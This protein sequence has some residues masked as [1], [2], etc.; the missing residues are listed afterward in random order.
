[1]AAPGLHLSQP[2]GDLFGPARVQRLW[3]L[4]PGT[5][6]LDED[7]G[8]FA[9]QL[10][11]PLGDGLDGVGHVRPPQMVT[12]VQDREATMN[13]PTLLAVRVIHRAREG[14]NNPGN[15]E[16]SGLVGSRVFRKAGAI[17]L[18]ALKSK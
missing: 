9:G 6:L 10:H 8:V 4:Q 7:L 17:Q 3:L 18:R 13:R 5:E 11:S 12:P 1:V 14:R 15:E 16:L 2:A